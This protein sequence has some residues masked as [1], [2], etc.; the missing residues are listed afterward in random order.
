MFLQMGQFGPHP[1]F[2]ICFGIMAAWGIAVSWGCG[3]T[4][5][6]GVDVGAG[7]IG[8]SFLDSNKFSDTDPALGHGVPAWVGISSGGRGLP[9]AEPPWVGS[10]GISLFLN[11]S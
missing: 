4:F 7:E 3:S 5:T 10:L 1:H 8:Q 2:S 11:S 9:P 6:V